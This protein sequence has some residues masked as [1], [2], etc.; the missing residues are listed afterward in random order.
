MLFMFSSSYALRKLSADEY[1]RIFSRQMNAIISVHI[2]RIDKDG[3]KFRTFS[4]LG[5]CAYGAT[6]LKSTDIK[7]YY[8]VNR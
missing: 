2:T 1:P 3:L 5:D 6:N 8:K 7:Q 4:S